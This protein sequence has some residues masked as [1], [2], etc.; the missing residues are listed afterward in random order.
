MLC[1]LSVD[2]LCCFGAKNFILYENFTGSVQEATF[3]APVSGLCVT[4][5]AELVRALEKKHQAGSSLYAVNPSAFKGM[6]RFCVPRRPA[7]SGKKR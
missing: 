2:A 7:E 6:L 5:C 4:G 1:A 3:A